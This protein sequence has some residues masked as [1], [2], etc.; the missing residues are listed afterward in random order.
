MLLSLALVLAASVLHDSPGEAAVSPTWLTPTHPEDFPD[1]FILE[2]DGTY[3]AYST[4]SA[5]GNVPMLRSTDLASWQRAG[6]AMPTAPAW[7]QNDGAWAPA[8]LARNGGYILYSALVQR[9]NGIRCIGRVTSTSPTGPFT[10]GGTG[11]IVCQP[12]LNGSID[13]SVFVAGDDTP[14]LI[15]KSEGVP[16]RVPPQIWVQQLTDD[17]LGVVGPATAILQA[18]QPWEF[19]LVENPSMVHAG[20]RFWLFY[21]GNLWDTSSYAVGYASCTSPQGPCAKPPN[22]RLISTQGEALSGPG[23]PEVFLDASGAHWLA[24]HAWSDRVGYASGGRRTLRLRRVDFGSRPAL[25]DAANN[26][27][28]PQQLAARVPGED[29]YDTAASFASMTVPPYAPVVY[30]ATGERF[31]DA[32]AGGPAAGRENSPVLLVTLDTLPQRTAEELARLRPGH[33]VVVGGTSVISDGVYN[34]LAPFSG[35]SIHRESGVDRYDTAARVSANIFRA[36]GVPVAYVATGESFADALAAG[37]AAVTNGG[38]V[39]LVERHAIP[40]VT[41]RELARLQPRHIT[42]VGGEQ[43]VSSG[44]E[45]ALRGYAEVSRVF[46]DDRYGTAAVLAATH[47]GPPVGGVTVATGENFP[48]AVAAGAAGFPILLVPPGDDIPGQVADVLGQLRPQGVVVVGGP[49]V[50]PDALVASLG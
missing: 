29:R 27:L 9:S 43:A 5:Q 41:E 39:L 6:D 50:V 20:D 2:V 36:P 28:S 34:A 7:A 11:P 26:Q 25:A 13:P 19:P 31:P 16:G 42:I 14:F 30:V 8:V 21:S 32:L 15:W 10:G 38:P 48:D 37:A 47:F 12:E 24:F 17:G 44:V 35:G 18:D 1:P 4:D 40:A 45:G 46:G 49:A 22:R 3:Y 33:I 23:G